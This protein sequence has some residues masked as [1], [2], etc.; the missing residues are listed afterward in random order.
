MKKNSN[1]IVRIYIGVPASSKSTQAKEF[2]LKN[3]KWIRV[4]RDS[5]REM[6]R[7]EQQ[8]ENT[9]ESMITEMS[10]CAID[11][12]LSRKL[13]IIIDNTNLKRKYI[14]A[15]VEYV[16]YRA[17][18]EFQI[19]DISLEKAIERDAFRDKKVGE[20]VIKRM[21]QE[22]MDLMSSF[23]YSFLNKKTF[24]Y[25]DPEFDVTLPKAVM[26]DLD[27]TLCHANGKRGYFDWL[28]V[29]R[30]DMDEV[31]FET[32]KLYKDAGYVII[33]C[34]GRDEEA[35]PATELWLN[36]YGIEYDMLLMRSK[37][38]MDKDIKV[39]KAL[40]EDNVKGK[41]NVRCVFED[42]QQVVDMW[43]ENGLKVFQ[44]SRG[45]Y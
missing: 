7:N 12:A 24:I 9:I 11:S 45:E 23:N 42:R 28:K 44:V 8:C 35:R 17:D 20:V 13:N 14:D 2:L 30:D 34:T 18:V 5:F 31:L 19:F 1:P 33:I 10:Y 32:Y 21:Y 4:N 37:G 26:I 29:D 15:I 6:L 39:K 36:S 25:K 41:Y 27:G 22:Y 43:R 16:K 38:L 40:W 3:P